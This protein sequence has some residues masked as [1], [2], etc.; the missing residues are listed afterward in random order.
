[1][2]VFNVFAH[3]FAILAFLTI[4]SLLVIV[5]LHILSVEDAVAQLQAL[6]ASPLHSLRT[7]CVGLIFIAVGLTFSRIL[8]KK[9]QEAEAL[10]FHTEIGPIVVSVTA[11]EEVVKKV[12]KRFHLVKEWKTKTMIQGKDVE[13]KLQFVLWAGGKIPELLTEIQQEIRSRLK[14]MLAPESQVEITCNVQRIEEHDPRL[15]EME[16]DKAASF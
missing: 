13:I 15:H 9:R 4:G 8:V 12:L 14:K 3:I 6:Y 16:H 1:M 5:S 11:I 7:G 2:K 10:I